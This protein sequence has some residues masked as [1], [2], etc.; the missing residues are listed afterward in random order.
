MRNRSSWLLVQIW[1]GA[2]PLK[3]WLHSPVHRSTN[4]KIRQPHIREYEA[5]ESGANFTLVTDRAAQVKCKNASVGTH[6]T[7]PSNIH[8]LPDVYCL[9]PVHCFINLAQNK[10]KRVCSKLRLTPEV[11]ARLVQ[12]MI[13]WWRCTLVVISLST[14]FPSH[15][16]RLPTCVNFNPGMENQLHV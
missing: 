7:T 11:L 6:F 15:G 5:G 8:V 12:T 10:L 2:R 1:P 14:H 13:W 4:V 3:R 16:S 9:L